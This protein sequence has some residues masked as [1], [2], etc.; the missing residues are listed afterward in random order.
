ME[1]QLIR[2]EKLDC[3]LSFIK[4]DDEIW[5]KGNS[6]AQALGYTDCKQAIRKNVDVEDCKSLFELKGVS[7]TPLKGNG[8]SA[9]FINESGLYSLI[10]ASKLPK[11]K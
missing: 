4:V 1:L 6:V 2:N 9:K 7:Q 10:L 5:F 8:K 3:S 11:V